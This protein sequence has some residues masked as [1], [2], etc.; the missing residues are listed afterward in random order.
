M[1]SIERKSFLCTQFKCQAVLSDPQIGPY[2]GLLLQVRV[3][4]RTKFM[5]KCSVFLKPSDCLITYQGRS[6][7]KSYSFAEMQSVYST[8]LA[9]WARHLLGC[10]LEVG[11]LNSSIAIPFTNVDM[12]LNKGTRPNQIR[13]KIHC[14]TWF[15]TQ[16]H[17]EYS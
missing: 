10:G 11:D 3:N 8:A 17:S 7:K 13:E 12:P 2:Q 5:K 1:Y 16:C 15:N 4:L 6:L 9:D 14:N